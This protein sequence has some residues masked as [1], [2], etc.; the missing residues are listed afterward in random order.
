[1]AVRSRWTP[2]ATAV[3]A[4]A[5]TAYEK[6][7]FGVVARVEES[8]DPANSQWIDD[9]ASTVRRSLGVSL[10]E[11]SLNDGFRAFSLPLSAGLA[12]LCGAVA[13]FMV[14]KR[15]REPMCGSNNQGRTRAYRSARH[16]SNTPPRLGT[17]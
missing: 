1:M 7:Q 8:I 6:I 13:Y 12:L 3:E 16:V 15:P 4:Q 14:A 2:F 17:T 10:E 5:A 9:P 11:L